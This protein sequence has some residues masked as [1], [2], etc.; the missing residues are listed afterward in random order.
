MNPGGGIGSPLGAVRDEAIDRAAHRVGRGD[1]EQGL[2]SAVEEDDAAVAV[3][4]DDAVGDRVDELDDAQLALAQRG[5]HRQPLADVEEGRHGAVDPARLDDR[6]RPVLDRERR[7]VAAP[8]GELRDV[9]LLLLGV[10]GASSAPPTAAGERRLDD[11]VDLEAEQLAFVVVA[12]HLQRGAVDE[13]ALA[14][15]VDA[16]QALGG[17]VEQALQGL[18]AVAHLSSVSAWTLAARRT[19]ATP[20]AASKA[21]SAALTTRSSRCVCRDASPSCAENLLSSCVRRLLRWSAWARISDAD[22]ARLAAQDPLARALG[23]LAH[24]LDDDVA[25]GP[26]R[27]W[28]RP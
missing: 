5:L 16:E 11:V 12:E 23:E 22:A 17:G 21:A 18:L 27:R 8:E 4:R 2:G 26:R 1:A 15:G 6:V 25:V 9:H 20:L 7:S 24:L 3:D 13:R 28:R 19:K 10:A 14:F